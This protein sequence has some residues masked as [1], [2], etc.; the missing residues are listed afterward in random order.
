[1]DDAKKVKEKED[2]LKELQEDENKL[3]K[4]KDKLDR[5]KL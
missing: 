3:T 4:Y 1:M 5:L 2:M